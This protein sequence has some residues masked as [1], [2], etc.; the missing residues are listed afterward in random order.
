[1]KKIKCIGYCRVSTFHQ[2]NISNQVEQI[3]QVAE[4]RSYDLVE[5]YSDEGI[6][7]S[8]DSRPALDK[9]IR[10]AQKG[11]F[12]ILLCSAIDRIGRNLGH[13]ISLVNNLRSYGVK[14]V[15]IREQ[16]NMDSS[17]GILLFNLFST[18]AEYEKNLISERVRDSLAIKKAIAEK[19]GNGWR[20]GRPPIS[21]NIKYHIIELH[22]ENISIRKIAQQI[23]TISK[24]TVER[25]IKEYKTSKQV[26][27]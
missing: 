14:C 19:T 22:K 9:L 3:K 6:S 27:E 4:N 1:M 10:D 13:L 25:V 16:I 21:D 8:K 24:S 26:E 15:F 18:L 2:K 7:G 20:C 23:G 12:Q 17:H 5:I 11:N